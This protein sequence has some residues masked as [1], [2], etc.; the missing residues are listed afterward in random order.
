T[1]SWDAAGDGAVVQRRD[2][3][4]TWTQIG[5]VLSY[6]TASHGD[7]DVSPEREYHYRVVVFTT[8][9]RQ[10]L[11]NELQVNTPP[12]GYW[13]HEDTSSPFEFRGS[14]QRRAAG[15]ASG[16]SASVSADSDAGVIFTWKGTA[17]RLVMARGP[18]LGMARV[19]LD[20]TTTY[21]NLYA[22]AGQPQ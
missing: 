19:E 17:L 6:T 20:A 16:G 3:S 15:Q 9:G 7:V 18:Q 21:L 12:A 4:G 8:D 13:R 11:S 1:L 5:P 14:W 10:T 22:P 2:E